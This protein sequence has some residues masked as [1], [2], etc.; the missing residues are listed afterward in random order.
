MLRVVD[1]VAEVFWVFAG[2]VSSCCHHWEENYLAI[3][4]NSFISP[5]SFYPFN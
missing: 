2:S 5:S 4:M 3:I 1:S